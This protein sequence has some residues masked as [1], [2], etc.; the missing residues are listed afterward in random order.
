MVSLWNTAV[1]MVV[2][3]SFHGSKNA[4]VP[5]CGTVGAMAESFW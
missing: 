3:W 4:S 5:D 1:P 2:A